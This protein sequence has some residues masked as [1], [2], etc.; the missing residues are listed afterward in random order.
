MPSSPIAA[1]VDEL[2]G[3][4]PDRIGQPDVVTEGD[5]LELLQ[6][7]AQVPDPR[8]RRGVRYPFAAILAVAVCAMLA[9][10]RSFVAI[11]EWVADLP[12]Q[13]RAGLGFDRSDPRAGDDLAGA[14]QRGQSRV[15]GRDRGLDPGP[16]GDRRCR[17]APHAET[18]ASGAAGARGGRQDDARHPPRRP[19]GAPAGRA[20]PRHR[21]VLAQVDVDEKTNEIPL[22]S[23]ALD[24]IP[25]ITG[26]VTTV[27][28]M[29]AQTAH[30]DY[31]HRRGAHVL[32]TVKGNQPTR[33]A[34]LKAL[35][36]NAVPIG[37][38]STGRG[39]AGSRRAP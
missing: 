23:T 33:H 16:P 26:V 35:P 29:H 7:L 10:A 20:R 13:A 6:A 36:W 34:Q 31:L 9:G 27:D 38:T 2:A 18:P 11:G 39:H 3:Q 5:R 21:L 22:F 17:R 4:I 8:S 15:G 19:P 14:D 30:A 32:V 37:H 12:E 25:D 1:V 28:A 24:Q